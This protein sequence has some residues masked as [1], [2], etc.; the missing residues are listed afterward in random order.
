M[1][2]FWSVNIARARCHA[3]P[4]TNHR[5]PASALQ[6]SFKTFVWSWKLF[7]IHTIGYCR[8]LISG[9]VVSPVHKFFSKINKADTKYGAWTLHETC[10]HAVV[11]GSS[12]RSVLESLKKSNYLTRKGAKKKF[13]LVYIHK[14]VTPCISGPKSSSR[15]PITSAVSDFGTMIRFFD[16]FQ[17]VLHYARAFELE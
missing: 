12:T 16:T 15:A 6:C 10:E 7:H 14:N 1:S 2:D 13:L 9:T 17:S 4:S 8:G 3:A 11:S 5:Y